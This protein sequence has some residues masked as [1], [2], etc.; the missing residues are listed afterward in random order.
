MAGVIWVGLVVRGIG[1]A[2]VLGFVEGG[3]GGR[4]VLEEVLGFEEGVGR[5][6]LEEALG[7]E[8]GGLGE[9]SLDEGHILRWFLGVCYINVG[10]WRC[11][12]SC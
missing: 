10:R 11:C 2:E 8:E 4:E 9:W 1:V 5:E 7:F 3:W 6:V 12:L